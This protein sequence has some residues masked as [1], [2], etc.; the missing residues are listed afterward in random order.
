MQQTLSSL[1]TSQNKFEN[2]AE[3]KDANNFC[4]TTYKLLRKE[5][6]LALKICLCHF[7]IKML[8]Y[9]NDKIIKYN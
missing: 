9:W 6:K 8:K 2:S 7:I 4:Q 5:D 1:A 3:I